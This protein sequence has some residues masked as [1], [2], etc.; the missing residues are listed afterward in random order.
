MAAFC[1]HGYSGRIDPAVLVDR[2]RPHLLTGSEGTMASK[3]FSAGLFTDRLRMLKD[4]P[5]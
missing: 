5:E 3:S 2:L 1:R 4:Q